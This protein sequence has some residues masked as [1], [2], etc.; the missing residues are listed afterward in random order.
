MRSGGF[1]SD[2][3]ADW[4]WGLKHFVRFDSIL[5]MAVS[6]DMSSI[7]EPFGITTKTLPLRG[8]ERVTGLAG[9]LKGFPRPG[10]QFAVDA[11]N[12]GFGEDFSYGSGP[13]MRM[14]IALGPKGV[15]GYNIV[16]G[17]QSGLNDSPHYADQAA[18]W[19]A[20]E[21]LPMHFTVDAVVKHAE[22]REQLVPDTN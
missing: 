22:L 3:P 16:P 21:A 11:A 2:N 15:R 14:A 10:D 5:A 12:F 17:G 18:M 1:G 6:G 20:N 4:L 9:R 13:V 7:F 8:E 19:L